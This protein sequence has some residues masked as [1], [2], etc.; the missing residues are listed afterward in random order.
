MS[1]HITSLAAALFALLSAPTG[2]GAANTVEIRRFVY[3]VGA[4]DGGGDRVKL[5]Y[6]TTDAEKVARVVRDLGGVRRGDIRVALTSDVDVVRAGFDAV[7]REVASGRATNVRIEFV[8]YYSGHSDEDGLLLAG[9]R[10]TY[11]DLRERIRGVPADV[12]VAIL[13]SCASGAFTRLKGGSRQPAFLVDASSKVSGY[14]FISSSSVDEAAQESDR[15]AASFFTHYLVSGLRG[16]ADSNRDG[17]VTLSEAYQFAFNETVSRTETTKAGA[18]HP[19]YNMHLAGT[20]DVVMTDLRATS[21]SL[22]VG[23]DVVGRLFMRDSAGHLVVELNKS[24]GSALKLGLSPD[25]YVVILQRGN[26]LFRAEVELR[27]ANTTRLDGSAFAA[28]RGDATVMRGGPAGVQPVAELKQVPV[29]FSVVPGLSTSRDRHESVR[30]SLNL[31]AGASARIDGVE[32]GTILNV[33]TDGV[34]GGQVVGVANVSAG[35]LHGLQLAGVGN[36]AEGPVHGAQLAGVGNIHRGRARGGPVG[37]VANAS[38]GTLSGVQLAG[39]ANL[40]TGAVRGAQLAGVANFSTST[41]SGLQLAGVLNVAKRVDGLQLGVINVAED[42]TASLGLINLVQNG[43]RAVEVWASDT[44]PLHMGVKLGA[45]R[46]YTLLAAGADANTFMAGV[47]LGVH[48][49]RNGYYVDV[50]VV[51]YALSDHKL[52]ETDDD[53]LS[54]LRVTLGW[55]LSN[56]FAAIVG[57]TVTAGLAFAG[58]PGSD[59]SPLATRTFEGDRVVLRLSPG[60]LAGIAYR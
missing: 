30:L 9:K 3:V 24:H 27:E 50:D 10:L 38:S 32:V 14:A 36:Y 37:G 17:R 15:I 45:R 53:L 28:I 22:L 35:D 1:L 5:R 56:H 6:A 7:A 42:S 33:A 41:V 58:K 18:Q 31:F 49:P 25:R 26:Q 2:S 40:S 11:R 51:G 4:N 46:T 48:T 20:G 12:T 21:A 16:G 60:L 47:G 59:L 44:T 52:N 19:A 8:F 34:R 57:A 29:K 43:Y 55:S 13:D 54:K 23:A 39:V